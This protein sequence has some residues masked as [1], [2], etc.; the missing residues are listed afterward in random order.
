MV[1]KF[2]EDPEKRRKQYFKRI[3]QH[4][5]HWMSL[6]ESGRLKDIDIIQTP[7]GEDIYFGDLLVG[8]DDLPPRQRQAFELVCLQGYT[9]TA[10]K[11]ALLP[12]S[13]SSS[14]I[15]E[16]VDTALTRMVRAYDEKQA[17]IYKPKAQKTK[18]TTDEEER[19]S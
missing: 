16:Y 8:L 2:P 17:G 18:K 3:Y 13:K 19:A 4:R 11:E 14:P 12:D 7:E 5:Q 9:E 10:A 15:Q 1:R 6:M